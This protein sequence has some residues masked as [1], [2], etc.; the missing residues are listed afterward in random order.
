MITATRRAQVPFPRKLGVSR[1]LGRRR[2]VASR[3]KSGGVSSPHAEGAPL[4]QVSSIFPR[5]LRQAPSESPVPRSPAL[6]LI[7]RMIPPQ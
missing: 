7:E 5:V 3:L 1:P 2:I 6:K 4:V